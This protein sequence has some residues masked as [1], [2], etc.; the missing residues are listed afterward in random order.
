[1]TLP[2]AGALLTAERRHP[3]VTSI[4]YVG[5]FYDYDNF[6]L[7]E[8]L[9]VDGMA[10]VDVGANIGSYSMRA[11]K[12]VGERGSVLALEPLASEYRRLRNNTQ[13]LGNVVLVQAAAGATA[14]RLRLAGTGQTTHHLSTAP[15]TNGE[16]DTVPVLTLDQAIADHGLLGS[17]AF[18]KMDVEGWEPA[19]I[20]GA[21][22]WLSSSG[23]T[24]LIVEANGL[25]SRCADS[26]TW[27]DAVR[28][29]HLAG[30]EFFEYDH[31]SRTLTA[32]ARPGPVAARGD[33]IVLRPGAVARA[34]GAH[35]TVG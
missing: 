10:F 3:V 31:T 19:V 24:G 16:G 26:A 9:L 28:I 29:L 21:A 7:M 1:V 12:L 25:Q 35:I 18:V 17:E 33:Y 6:G 8:A 15:S 30:F 13:R 22:S 2:Y 11:S 14:G 32:V 20:A 5:E 4:R 27:E 34:K 23:P